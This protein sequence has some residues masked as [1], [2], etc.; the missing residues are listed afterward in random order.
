MERIVLGLERA[1]LE[2]FGLDNTS[3][4]N[5]ATSIGARNNMYAS[6]LIGCYESAIEYTVL[7]QQSLETAPHGKAPASQRR[8]YT[9][10]TLS[11][12]SSELVLE[13]FGKMRKLH[14]IVREKVTMP[15][16]EYSATTSLQIIRSR[17]RSLICQSVYI[18]P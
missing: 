16:G 5:M 7:R 4:F 11:R 12:E 18:I 17:T 13:L 14:D 15:R 9:D 1:G 10:V 8:H 3:D 6:L 2:D